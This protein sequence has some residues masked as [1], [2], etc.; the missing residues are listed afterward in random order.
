MVAE[1]LG[2]DLDAIRET[3]EFQATPRDI[4]TAFGLV[5]AGTVG[6]TRAGCIGVV[7]G[8]GVITI[9]HVDAIADDLAPDW[10][11]GRTGGTDG[12]WRVIIDGEPSFDAEF[13]VGYSPGEDANDPGL[14]ANAVTHV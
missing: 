10:P 4:S 3:C 13:E 8:L 6:A 11:K 7:D 12:I 2:V 5:D 1:A 14:F 9:E